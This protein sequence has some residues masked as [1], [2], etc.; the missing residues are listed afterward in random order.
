[1]RPAHTGVFTLSLGAWVR[2]GQSAVARG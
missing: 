2:I 1:V